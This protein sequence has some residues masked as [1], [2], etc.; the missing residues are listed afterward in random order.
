MYDA[1]T[2]GAIPAM[3]PILSCGK[4]RNT[5]NTLADVIENLKRIVLI[6]DAQVQISRFIK[7]RDVAGKRYFGRLTK[8]AI[9][10]QD[11]TGMAGYQRIV[12]Q[13]KILGRNE[14]KIVGEYNYG[15][16]NLR[17]RLPVYY[18]DQWLVSAKK[19][20]G[21]EAKWIR[22]NEGKRKKTITSATHA[23]SG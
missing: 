8:E 23:R 17:E 20:S 19:T 12:P 2:H 5:I 18:R 6:S 21:N 15:N 14:W 4:G 7:H 9:N 1:K 3:V 13:N 11:L 10:I 22:G 16:R